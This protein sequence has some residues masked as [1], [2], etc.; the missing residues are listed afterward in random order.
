MINYENFASEDAQD[1]W[2]LI[3]DRS[4][5][6]LVMPTGNKPLPDPMSTLIYN[7]VIWVN[8][9][10]TELFSWLPKFWI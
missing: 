2:R 6:D 9:N 7:T 3:D 1:L 10:Y 4:L 5:L 8:L